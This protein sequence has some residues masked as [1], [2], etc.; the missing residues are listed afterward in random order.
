MD[1]V[2]RMLDFA[3]MTTGPHL[4]TE[5]ANRSAD[6]EG[7]LD[8][9]GRPIEGGEEAVARR[10]DL[11]ATVRAER[12]SSALVMSGDELPPA[13]VADP[14]G[15][16]RRVDDVREQKRRERRWAPPGTMVLVKPR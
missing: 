8:R 5:V 6:L 13:R 15:R 9:A 1:R 16:L 14:C 11:V 12:F 4:E 2:G 3:R 10:I 7:T